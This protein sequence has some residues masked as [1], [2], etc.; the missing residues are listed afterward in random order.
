MIIVT[1]GAGFIGSCLVAKLNQ[2]GYKDILIVDNLGCQ[3]KWKNLANK[4]FTGF[5]YKDKFR[6]IIRQYEK[7]DNLYIPDFDNKNI[8]AVIHL[9]A[10]SSTTETNA[11]YL[12]DNNFLYTKELA[13]FALSRGIRF[14]YASSAATYGDGK[15]GYSDESIDNL[16]PLNCYGLSKHLF[17][18][19]LY[20]NNLQNDVTGVKF[21]N[22]FGPNE[23]HK[24]DMRSMFYKAFKQIEQT[25]KV[26]LFKSYN[27][28]Y[29]DGEQKRD[30]IYVKDCV[31]IFIKILQDSSFKGLYNIGTG[32]AHTWNELANS[33][34]NAMNRIPNI[35]YIEMPEELKKQYQYFTEADTK[36]LLNKLGADWSFTSIEEAAMDYVQN[37]LQLEEAVW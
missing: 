26:R 22:V 31:D 9:G 16:T 7:T 19:W 29:H 33:V 25:G 36:K 6:E 35:E 23:Y 28:L 13:K 3:L 4:K 17:D 1:G 27:P 8:D 14:V 30:F 11:N 5:L 2:L 18:M 32:Q 12:L 10:C 37:Y 21:F 24:G 34:F 15:N 20:E